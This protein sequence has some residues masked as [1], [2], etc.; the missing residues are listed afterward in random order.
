MKTFFTINFFLFVLASSI[1]AQIYVDQSATGSNDGSSWTNAYT[2]LTDALGASAPNDQIWVAAGTYKP[3][4]GTAN[5]DTFYTF[6]HDLQ[7]YGGFAGTETM[8]SERDWATNVT[9]LS[10]DH[11]DDDIDDDF[12][13][14]K[15]DNSLHV[16]WL[17]D[18]VTVASTIDGFTIRNG[19]TEPSS[20]AGND[21]R[22]GGILTYGAPAVRNCI[23]TQNYGW[24]G[25]GLYPR[26]SGATGVII[27]DC[28]FENNEGGFG[29][30]MYLN[31]DSGAVTNTIFRNNVIETR[32]GGFYNNT[33]NGIIV[34]DCTF[35]GNECVGSR[36]G[37]V[38]N[39]E[40]PSTYINCVFTD[41]KALNS[42]GGGLQIRDGSAENHITVT[43]VDCSFNGNQAEFGGGIGNYDQ[44]TVTEVSNCT[45]MNNTGTAVGGGVSNAFGAGVTISDCIFSENSS[46]NG[47]ALFSQND[48]ARVTI[49]NTTMMSNSADDRGGAISISGDDEPTIGLPIPELNLENTMIV[50]NSSVEQGGGINMGNGNL[51]AVNVLIHLNA[52]INTD[53]IGGGISFNTNDSLTAN[54]S[55]LNTTIVDNAA[56]I[57]AGISSWREENSTVGSSTLTMQNTVLANIAG[58]NYELEAGDPTVVSNGGNLSQD[59]TLVNVFVNTNDLN[60]MDPLFVDYGAGDF[61][62]LNDS[63]CVDAGVAAG[64]PAL[65]IEGNSRIDEVDMGAFE[66]QKIVN[67]RE[68]NKYFGQLDIYPNPVEDV[69]NFTF[70]SNWNGTLY[71]NVLS[72][73]GKTIESRKIEK[74]I[75]V[76]S[77][78]FNVENLPKGMYNLSVSN[79]ILT[80]TKSFVK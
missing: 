35:E 15:T 42:S 43:V 59:Q 36:G 54:F 73:D 53:G 3:G 9:I 72:I 45:F 11:N 24:F 4:S 2:D 16:M 52:V 80:N 55:I 20:G 31:A 56:T 77:T 1:Q 7:L 34:A 46:G 8:L 12:N 66:N 28:V 33:A 25:G 18:T 79:G 17:T 78:N 38:Y 19:N 76:L 58:T 50:F 65:D 10:G 68:L 41:N 39:S 27:E 30:G 61:H 69:L 71:V 74:N 57:G 48:S 26:G 67:V 29:G 22:G 37:G 32:G 6:P 21:R 23:F 44:Y 63:P 5:I 51:N 13:S 70:E 40:S 60:G 62:L 14:N 75:D 64:A 49:V 47:G